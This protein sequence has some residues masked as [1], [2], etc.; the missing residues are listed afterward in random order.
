VS[1][2]RRI[3]VL[4]RFETSRNHRTVRKPIQSDL[5]VV[6]KSKGHTVPSFTLSFSKNPKGKSE[7]EGKF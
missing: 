7:R 5:G 1:L 4:Q 3:L 6:L 2:E